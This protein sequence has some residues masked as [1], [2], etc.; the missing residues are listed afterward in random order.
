MEGT[1]ASHNFLLCSNLKHFTLRES[2]YCQIPLSISISQPSLRALPGMTADAIRRSLE[3]M[4]ISRQA[5]F[6][7]C[8]YANRHESPDVG[9]RC[10]GKNNGIAVRSSIDAL[11]SALQRSSQKVHISNVSY[12]DYNRDPIPLGNAF[13]SALHKNERFQLEREVR[14]LLQT[15]GHDS[16]VC[17][18]RWKHREVVVRRSV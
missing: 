16:T 9:E 15:G 4:R 1:S 8:W 11:R 13:L 17:S 10:G 2:T 3:L 12:I 6:V 18:R 14:A 5:I 7:N